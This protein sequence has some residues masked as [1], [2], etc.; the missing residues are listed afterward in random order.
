MTRKLLTRSA[1][2]TLLVVL[3]LSL[4]VGG[5][6]YAASSGKGKR[7]SVCVRHKGGALYRA[8]K[9]KRHD[10]KL[11]WN[12]AGRLGAT[13]K[14]GP[15]GATGG[16]GATGPR[17]PQGK[18]GATGPQGLKG[19]QGVPGPVGQSSAITNNLASALDV[20]ST[21]PSSP[22]VINTLNLAPG[23][24]VITATGWTQGVGPSTATIHCGIDSGTLAQGTGVSLPASSEGSIAATLPVT[25]TATTTEK[26]MCD[27]VDANDMRFL[28]SRLTAVQ[29]GTITAQ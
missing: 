1:R 3:A 14:T 26:F 13:G 11:S 10:A 12:T 20:A 9:C 16:R 23:S 25:L 8:K 17:G 5:A 2:S 21:D 15:T 4:A 27:R 7:I 19:A 6:A 24:Y 18:T 29:V 22:T 28:G